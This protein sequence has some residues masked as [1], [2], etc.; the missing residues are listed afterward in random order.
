MQKLKFKINFSYLPKI[1]VDEIEA[2]IYQFKMN[3]GLIMTS[4]GDKEYQ[5]LLSQ[6][7]KN[8]KI[9]VNNLSF[10]KCFDYTYK[11]FSK[12][13]ILLNF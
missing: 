7:N 11:V 6:G 8:C 1:I 10:E 5:S 4:L 9:K 3:K 12:R 13:N 2:P